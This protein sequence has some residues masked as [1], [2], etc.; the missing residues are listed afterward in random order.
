MLKIPR[1]TKQE[2]S[3]EGQ[4]HHNSS[5]SRQLSPIPFLASITLVVGDPAEHW[6]RNSASCACCQEDS[7]APIS[8]GRSF[9]LC[10][11]YWWG[12]LREAQRRDLQHPIN[13]PSYTAE[14]IELSILLN[15]AEVSSSYRQ[16]SVNRDQGLDVLLVVKV[17]SCD[18]LN[19]E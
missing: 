19:E 9:F 14:Q 2:A 4:D 17:W 10:C 18:T 1:C 3:Q 12:R 6:T 11:M 15:I 5:S 13:A 16:H 8:G 7:S